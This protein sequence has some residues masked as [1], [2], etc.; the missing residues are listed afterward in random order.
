[1]RMKK[2]IASTVMSLFVSLTAYGV[3]TLPLPE[4]GTFYI[5]IDSDGI[6]LEIVHG[7]PGKIDFCLSTASQITWWKGVKIF[8]DSSWTEKA[9]LWTQDG[10][11]GPVCKQISVNELQE[12]S[13]RIE[14]WKAKAF[15]VHTDMVHY[16]FS[17]NKYNGKRIMLEWL[18]D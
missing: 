14:L 3:E 8:G 18:Y 9:L 15:G 4:E 16:T 17:P 6:N 7:T 13:S 12:S 10:V 2:I 5:P 11:H 1:M